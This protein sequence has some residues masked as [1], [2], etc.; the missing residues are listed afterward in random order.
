MFKPWNGNNF[1]RSLQRVGRM[2]M[3][4]FL[5][6][7]HLP[8]SGKYFRSW[9]S[10][11]V[12]MM[13]IKTVMGMI[14][15]VTWGDLVNYYVTY[16]W[17]VDIWGSMKEEILSHY[18]V[19]EKIAWEWINGKNHFPDICGTYGRRPT[20][21]RR[22]TIIRDIDIIRKNSIWPPGHLIYRQEH[23]NIF[24]TTVSVTCHKK[25]TETEETRPANFMDGFA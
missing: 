20:E 3:L 10:K 17:F 24:S 21:R 25:I 1:R 11:T 19:L 4:V 6:P 13:K 7:L 22:D 5:S 15:M 18:K 12:M 9:L 8:W 23:K 2:M 14:H 16:D